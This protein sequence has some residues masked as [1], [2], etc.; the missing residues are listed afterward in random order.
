TAVKERA[1]IPLQSRYDDPVA[2]QRHDLW[3]RFVTDNVKFCIWQ[4]VANERINLLYEKHHPIDVGPVLKP[5]DEKPVPPKCKRRDLPSNVNNVRNQL[6][7]LVRP[8]L[9]EHLLFARA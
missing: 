2:R 4:T 3:G 7:R 6:N 9:L 1:H 5:A 8:I